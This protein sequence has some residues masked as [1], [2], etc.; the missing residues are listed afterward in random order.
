MK[1]NAPRTALIDTS[2]ADVSLL[3]TNL[4]MTSCEFGPT[5]SRVWSRKRSWASP[6][7]PVRMRSPMNTGACS[8]RTRRPEIDPAASA[9]ALGEAVAKG[10]PD[11]KDLNFGNGVY[12]WYTRHGR[13]LDMENS[14]D[15]AGNR[16]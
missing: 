5:T 15:G 10:I 11:D 14:D 1:R 7:G 9:A 13:T 16:F 8:A 4:S 3:K 6:A 2:F 12:W